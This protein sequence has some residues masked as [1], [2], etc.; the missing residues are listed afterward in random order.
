MSQ[1]SNTGFGQAGRVRAVAI[2]D[3]LK[4]VYRFFEGDHTQAQQDIESMQYLDD[5]VAEFT[6]TPVNNA[7][8]P[9]VSPSTD[10]QPE[11]TNQ[12]AIEMIDKKMEDVVT[13]MCQQ[14]IADFMQEHNKDNPDRAELI[15]IAQ[16]VREKLDPEKNNEEVKELITKFMTEFM[17]V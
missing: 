16:K 11:Q 2:K 7:E 8:K 14:F 4:F 10:V 15:I 1:F 5:V 3:A 12:Q 9:Q 6:Q 13:N 17:A